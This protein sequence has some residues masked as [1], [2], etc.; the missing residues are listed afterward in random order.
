MVIFCAY[1]SESQRLA[2][3]L[4]CI[5]CCAVPV[6]RP[7]GDSPLTWDTR[8]QVEDGLCR[9]VTLR[10]GHSVTLSVVR[11]LALLIASLDTLWV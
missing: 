4:V 9:L 5:L 8:T 6:V 3:S 1:A 11:V 10:K 7:C 2:K